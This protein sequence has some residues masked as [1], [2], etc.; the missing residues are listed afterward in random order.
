MAAG[1]GHAKTASDTTEAEDHYFEF[2]VHEKYDAILESKAFG[3]S[4][5]TLTRRSMYGKMDH[6][7]IEFI[8]S[9]PF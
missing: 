1:G 2:L 5:R 8:E 4:T 7:I 3:K 9:F 6:A